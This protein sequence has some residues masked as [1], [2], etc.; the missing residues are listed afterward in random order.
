M[1]SRSTVA[2]VPLRGGSQG[3]PGKNVKPI[4]G[5]PL[6][7]WSLEAAC[8][9]RY[10]DRV[11]VST[12]SDS[13][14][15]IVQSFGLNIEV[16]DRPAQFATSTA[17][18]ESVMIDFA[19]RVDFETLVTIQATSPLTTSSDLD[20]A[21][22]T[23]H[24]EGYDSLVTG[25]VEKRFVW[26]LD[27]SPLNY[28]PA[29]RPRRQDWSGT[30]VEN[31]AFYLTRREILS[32]TNCRLGGKIGV[33]AMDARTAFE[34]DE[35][36][37]WVICESLLRR[38]SF[39]QDFADVLKNIK[40]VVCDV[41]GT[42]TDGGMYYDTEGEALKKFNTRDA[43]GLSMLQ[44]IGIHV[45]IVTRENSSV[46]AARAKKIG[47]PIHLGIQ[48]KSE[49]LKSLCSKQNATPANA[50][51]IGDDFNDIEIMQ[52]CAFSACPSDAMP[53]VKQ[54]ASYVAQLPGGN[55]AVREICEIIFEN[56]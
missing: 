38:R 34:I 44:S 23:F 55:G 7:R 35:P 36:D 20:R 41:D 32:T 54:V 13:I 51:M 24:E 25:V 52:R 16:I 37:D 17:S 29:K 45:A 48:D 28:D 31:G 47:I 39:E 4:A 43:H 10:I 42:L 14:K 8:A 56:H 27:G 21:I 33:Y 49:F 2:L 50:A 6:C 18:T 19:N 30:L 53:K 22:G 26:T 46:A 5:K 1:P 15:S 9:S 11:Y 12:D 3:I 40:L